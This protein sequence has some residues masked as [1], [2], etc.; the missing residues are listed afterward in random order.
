[1]DVVVSGLSGLIGSALRPALEAAG[2]R[3]I[4]LVRGAAEG[5][6]WDPYAE[7][8]DRAALSGV[9][10]VVHLSGQRIRAGRWTRKHKQTVLDSRTQTTRFLA[11]T[12]AG[13]DRPPS[14]FLSA[15]AVGV[16]GDRGDDEVTE[17][18]PA[19]EGF[20]AGLCQAWEAATAAADGAGI[21]TVQLRSG[22][23][24]SA[25]GGLL[26]KFRPG[27][28]VAGRLGPGM[29][30][31]SWISI[32][33]EVGAILH[34]LDGGEGPSGLAERAAGGG[35]VAGPVNLV[36]PNPVRNAEF[37]KTLA[38]VV[39][40]PKLPPVP[41]FA[42]KAIFGSEAATEAALV[43]Q[44]VRPARLEESG[45]RFAHPDLEPA[46]RAILSEA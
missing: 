42:I 26:P 1:M 39:R 14:A 6:R 2:H 12:L 13:L 4:P 10:A 40:R 21:R 41:S 35:S 31:M 37:V 44:R 46:L 30:W 17:A 38:A 25:D 36:A 9:D 20:L 23:V 16:Y 18:S 22:L 45:Y 27:P 7:T 8:I 43:S 34:L 29:Q 5:I 15:S 28:F 33:D 19:G 11:E 32:D 24:L 3:V